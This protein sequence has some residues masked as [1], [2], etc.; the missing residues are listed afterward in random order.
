MQTGTFY[1]KIYL[2]SIDYR[3]NGCVVSVF[4]LRRNFMKLFCQQITASKL[5]VPTEN[6]KPEKCCKVTLFGHK[7]LN[8]LAQH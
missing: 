1:R 8:H 6:Q 4:K 2:I 3:I 5:T 7:T